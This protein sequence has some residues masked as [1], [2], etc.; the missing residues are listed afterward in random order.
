MKQILMTACALALSG[1]LA[2]CG[3]PPEERAKVPDTGRKETR[4]IEAADGIGYGNAGVRK[5]V[6]QVLDT[7]DQRVDQLNESIDQQSQ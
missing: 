3:K 4:V 2:G 5:K 1:S 6:D 7:N